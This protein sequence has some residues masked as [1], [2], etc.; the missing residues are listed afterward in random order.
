MMLEMGWTE[1]QLME[2][3]SINAVFAMIEEMNRIRREN[4]NRK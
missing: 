1:R 2:D 3:N 4:K